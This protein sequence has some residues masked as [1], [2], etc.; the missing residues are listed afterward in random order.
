MI[1]LNISRKEHSMPEPIIQAHPQLPAQVSK[2]ENL[3]WL[4]YVN[5]AHE[6]IGVPDFSDYTREELEYALGSYQN[7]EMYVSL[8]QAAIVSQEWDK[9]GT[10]KKAVLL[11]RGRISEAE[12]PLSVVIQ[13]L[14]TNHG[15]AYNTLRQYA[16]V[17][18]EI[19]VPECQEKQITP[20]Q[21]IQETNMDFRLMRYITEETK[22]EKE[23][24]GK[25][26]VDVYR[27]IKQK[28]LENPSYSTTDLRREYGY[29]QPKSVPA[30]F[31][32]DVFCDRLILNGETGQILVQEKSGQGLE[33]EP[34]KGT[35]TIFLASALVGIL[36]VKAIG[37]GVWE[38]TD[39]QMSLSYPNREKG[40]R[41][42]KPEGKG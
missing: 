23:R 2:A 18:R 15:Q 41:V 21:F 7:Q 4:Q 32:L 27:E 31:W 14:S 30:R 5:K 22:P 26:S 24:T 1:N 6:L 10:L 16:A 9:Y 42:N 17:W 20:I 13:D 11:A 25:R 34:K 8:C 36:P 33:T 40:V 12:Y 35:D 19:V 3:K 39:I 37:D 38:A 29:L 28:K